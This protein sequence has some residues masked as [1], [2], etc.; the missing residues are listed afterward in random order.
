MPGV[1]LKW[2]TLGILGER[3]I[4]WS[5]RKIGT[6]DSICQSN[7]ENSANVIELVGVGI[8]LA[9]IGALMLIGN[10]ITTFETTQPDGVPL[11]ESARLYREKIEKYGSLATGMGCAGI[12]SYTIPKLTGDR[13][14]VSV[15]ESLIGMIATG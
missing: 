12:V 9:A 7:S 10:D 13:D 2:F 11:D 6:R 5:V 15:I 3:I 4:S 1:N 8:P 14:M